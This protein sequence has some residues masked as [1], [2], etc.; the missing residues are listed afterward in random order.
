[1]RPKPATKRASRGAMRQKEKS[2]SSKLIACSGNVAS[3]A[4][5]RSG[6]SPGSCAASPRIGDPHQGERIGPA[7]VGLRDG[8]RDARVLRHVLRMPGEAADVDV[9]RA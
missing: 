2:A 8:Q 3:H 6:W 1:M 5:F 4:A 9:E 7:V